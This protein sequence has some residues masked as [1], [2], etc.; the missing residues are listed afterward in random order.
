MLMTQHWFWYPGQQI[1]GISGTP[2]TLGWHYRRKGNQQ[3]KAFNNS[4]S[5][6]KDPW[7][8]TLL[9]FKKRKERENIIQDLETATREYT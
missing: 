1:E 3:W 5:E 2:E 6:G 8:K 4:E 7:E 9:E